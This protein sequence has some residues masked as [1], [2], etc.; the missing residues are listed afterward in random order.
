VLEDAGSSKSAVKDAVALH[1]LIE[2][3]YTTQPSS[4]LYSA[5]IVAEGL[6][7]TLKSVK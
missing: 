1:K 2:K 7:R 3:L 6:I 4:E 5:I